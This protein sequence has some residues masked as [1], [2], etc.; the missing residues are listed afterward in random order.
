MNSE[1][2][3]RRTTRTG[4]KLTFQRISFGPHVRPLAF[5]KEP[6]SQVVLRVSKWVCTDSVLGD[7]M[8]YCGHSAKIVVGAHR[9]RY[10]G[11]A[12]DVR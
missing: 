2:T 5:W 6:V 11:M 1:R 10:P 9:S 3:L 12:P 7:Q 4:K 8:I